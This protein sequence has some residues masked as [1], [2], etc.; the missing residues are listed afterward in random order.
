MGYLATHQPC[1][2]CGSSDAL[3]VNGDG[4]TFCFSCNHYDRS[5]ATSSITLTTPDMKI[6]KPQP[7]APPGD[8]VQGE[9]LEIAPRGIHLDTVRKMGYRIGK[10]GGRACHIADYYDDNRRL[11]GQK[12]RFEGKRFEIRG[13]IAK[14]FYGQ[15]LF[16]MGGK[17]IVITEG[18]IDALSVS[19][20]QDNK[21]PVVSIPTG[22]TSAVKVFKNNLE[23]LD[24]WDEVILMFDEDDAGRKAVENVV[25]LLP[26]GKAKVARLP[27]KDANECLMQRRSDE[28][29]NAI[30]RSNVW[31]PDCIVDGATLHE[32]LLN[33]KNT[34]SIPYPFQGLNHMTKGIRKGE[35]VTFCAGSGIGKSQVCR[36][37]AH[38]ILTTTDKSVG[39]IALEESVERTALG[40]VGLEMGKLLHL[41][42]ASISDSDEFN[43][44]YTKTVGSGRFWLYDHWGSLDPERLLSHVAHMSKAM[45]VEYIVLDHVSLVVSGMQDGDER[46]IIDNLMTKLRSL[47][48]ECNI[49]LL[50]VSHL[51]RPSD[52]RGHEEGALTSLAHLRGSAA[53]AQ[54]SDMVIGLER[55]QQDT[56]DKHTTAVRVLKNRFSGDT[57]IA[58]K[59]QFNI[60]NGRM[61]E[62]NFD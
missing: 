24:K 51:K 48:E 4:S 15:H 12:L 38:H 5:E 58:T 30:F 35:I 14:R 42:P 2:N 31:K 3:S 29:I 36:V 28:V 60:H 56:E 22:S 46:R 19:Q 32:R 39:Y 6:T 44:A 49:A 59:L 62:Y 10:V 16:P 55:N 47:V 50:L 25:G 57:G 54:L 53:I 1:V 37:I 41:D 9:Y 52:G 18:E 45:D 8:F 61:A 43:K 33:P 7:E 27:L 21:W 34:E 11:I 26:Q 40:V 13:D 17:K 20:I 23:W